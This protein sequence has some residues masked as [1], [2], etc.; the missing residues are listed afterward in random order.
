VITQHGQDF[1]PDSAAR[2]DLIA[3]FA[4]SFRNFAGVC[5]AYEPTRVQKSRVKPVV[6]CLNERAVGQ[7]ARP[8][9]VQLHPVWMGP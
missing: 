2:S 1:V 9:E 7:L 4:P 8:R 6:E 5:R 3:V